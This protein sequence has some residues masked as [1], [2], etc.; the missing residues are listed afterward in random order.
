[1]PSIPAR[2]PRRSTPSPRGGAMP[3]RSS[4]ASTRSSTPRTSALAGDRR[5]ARVPPSSSR[6]P[7]AAE[8]SSTGNGSAPSHRRGSSRSAPG[9]RASLGPEGVSGAGDR[10]GA[11]LH[12]ELPEDVLDV[13]VDRPPARAEDRADLPV[14]LA[15]DDPGEHL[16]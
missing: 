15:L 9:R 5:E 7:A 3:D 4:S 1:S 10:G 2:G 14:R 16:G 13:L 12:A 11:R 6:R 8:S